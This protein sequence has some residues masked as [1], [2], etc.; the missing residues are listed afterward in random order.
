MEVKR[1]WLQS[2]SLGLAIATIVSSVLLVVPVTNAFV[3]D[4]KVYVAFLA[5]IASVA[6]FL[7]Y[8]VKQRAFEFVLNPL[9]MAVFLFA[10]SAGAATFFANQ[11]PVENLLGLGGIIIASAL[12]AL[13]SGTT[14]PKRVVDPIL[15]TMAIVSALLTL[16]SVL[17]L[18]GYGP[19]HFINS[20][21]GVE[22]PTDLS[23]NLTGASLIAL[24]FI[25]VTLV[26]LAAA[27]VSKKHISK[28][29][30]I[31]LPIMLI[32]VAIHAWSMLPGKPGAV[33]LP[34]WSASW[35]VTLDAIRSPRS[36]LIGTG[37]AAYRNIYNQFKPLWVN[38]T[39]QWALTFNQAANGPLTI[40]STMGF[41]GLIAWLI[42]A[43]KITKQLKTANQDSK[44]LALMAMTTILLQVFLPFNVVML[45]IQA[46]LIGGLVAAEKDKHAFARFK[47]LSVKVISRS[48]T[49]RFGHGTQNFTTLYMAAGVS[50]LAVFVILYFVGRSYAALIQDQLAT[51]AALAN[52]AVSVYEHQQR[53]VALNP[54]LDVYR[55]NYAVTNMLIAGAI[56]NKKDLTEAEK[57]QVGQL[58]QQAVREARSATLLDQ[59]DSQNW[60]T[61]AQI[62][63]NMVGVSEDA[64]Q[65]SVQAYV[66]AIE[67]NPTDPNIRLALGQ[68]FMNQKA[69]GQAGGIFEQAVNI[70][71]NYAPSYYN[72]A[73]ALVAVENWV[74]AQAAYEETL[75]YLDPASPDHAQVV[76][77]LELIKPKADEVRAQQAKAAAAQKEAAETES[78]T[79]VT[80]PSIVEQTLETTTV[81]DETASDVD[82]TQEDVSST[83]PTPSPEP[84]PQ[85]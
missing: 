40:L 7:F 49:N 60:L 23:F 64:A 74:S 83:E 5:A 50:T 31:T 70:K 53:A 63:Q 65:W 69:F 24:Q 20:V 8:S 81:E 56:S 59:G 77:E 37:P 41:I 18:L 75:K 10:L 12:I 11:Y 61:L 30:A 16:T 71:P 36:A 4:T 55:R 2:V 80:T 13:F 35:S 6:L 28:I 72:L 62:Y 76:K 85:P 32:G 1:Q 15:N 25:G 79:E 22:L 39:D 43:G 67:T 48:Q 26:G 66:A 44:P 42:L 17:Q 84:S 73:T 14:L 19:A 82:L 68:I 54:Y 38:T 21:F 3:S 57:Q 47:A 45:V 9:I 78:S 29:V 34:S 27:V 46:V 52:D 33:Q 58:L 51:K